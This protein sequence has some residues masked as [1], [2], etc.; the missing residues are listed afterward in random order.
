MSEKMTKAELLKL[1]R[2]AR[3]RFEATLAKVPKERMDEPGVEAQ[4]SVKDILAHIAAWERRMVQWAG[5]TVRGIVPARASITE[6]DLDRINEQIYLENR[7]RPPAEIL[8]EFQESYTQVL[9]TVEETSEEDLIDAQRF[10]WRAGEPLWLM[11]AANT[12]WHY[13]EHGRAI[14]A[15]LEG[16][17]AAS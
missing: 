10:E 15:W 11:V 2:S 14:H 3:Q 5:E 17:E 4:W 7:D 6:E 8:T 9:G 16:A 13:E 12:F 1:V